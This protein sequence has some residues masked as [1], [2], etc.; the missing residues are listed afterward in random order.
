MKRIMKG[1]NHTSKAV[2]M[3]DGGVVHGAPMETPAPG[4]TTRKRPKVGDKSDDTH[5]LT[6]RKPRKPSKPPASKPAPSGSVFRD[7][8]GNEGL[9]DDADG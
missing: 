7:Y 3:A 5:L 4:G 1:C 2:G 9:I 6:P 8:R